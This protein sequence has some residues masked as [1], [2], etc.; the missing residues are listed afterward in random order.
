MPT[1]EDIMAALH[2]VPDPEMPISIVDLGMVESVQIDDDAVTVIVL[3]TF[4]GCPALDMIRGDI[5][6]KLGAVRGVGAISV[7]YVYDPPWSVDRISEAGRASLQEHGVTVPE[8]GGRRQRVRPH[9]VPLDLLL[10]RLP[11]LVRA[12]EEG[13]TGL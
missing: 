1:H 4:V 6:A 10:Q 13:V 7:E 9:E 12:H 2:E 3:P 5:E 11:Q 8:A